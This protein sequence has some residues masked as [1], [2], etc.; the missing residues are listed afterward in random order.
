MDFDF[1]RG[2]KRF[3]SRTSCRAQEFEA[4]IFDQDWIRP[5]EH[6]DISSDEYH[7]YL[8]EN[9]KLEMSLEEFHDAWSSVFL[10]GLIVPGATPGQSEGPLSAHSRIQ[11]Q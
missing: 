4:V 7:R 6:G 2:M 1:D 8:R 10:P 5:Y 9:G 3:A 11:Y